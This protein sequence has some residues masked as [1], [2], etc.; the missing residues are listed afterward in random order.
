MMPKGIL[1]IGGTGF[2]GRALLNRLNSYFPEIYTI[3]RKD[4]SLEKLSNVS[5]FRSSLDNSVL[6][7][8][9]L[10]CCRVVF[11]LASET[12][13]GSSILQPALEATNNL[14]PSLRL[15]ECLQEYS[16]LSLIYVST[17]GAIYGDSGKDKVSEDMPLFPLSY[18]GAGK[19]ALEKFI[20]AYS[21]QT[22][23]TALILRPSNI[24][25]PGQVYKQGFGIIP[26]I[27]NHLLKGETLQLWG[28]G[29]TTRDYLYIDDFVDFCSMLLRTPSL[30]NGVSRVFNIGSGKGTTIIELLTLIE[31]ITGESVQRVYQPARKVDVRRIVLDNTRINSKFQWSPRTELQTG[32]TKAWEW[33]RIQQ[34]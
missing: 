13:P 32:L 15:L 7:K 4:D 26:T 31:T 8:K 20:F 27:F 14:L 28:D 23:N 24:Y 33:F 16:H 10:P 34:K 30:E 22:G 2:V 9:I 6:L 17:G 29:T 18:Y 21:R 3:A 19:A 25:G 12:T 11:H 1:V 5:H